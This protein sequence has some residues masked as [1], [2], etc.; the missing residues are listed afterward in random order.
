MPTIAAWLYRLLD[1][2]IDD[3]W[4]NH[5]T[6]LEN[7]LLIQGEWETGELFV[8]GVALRPT[9]WDDREK[10]WGQLRDP[11]R[12]FWWGDNSIE[13]RETARAI[14]EWFLDDQELSMYLD[15]FTTDVV[16]KFPKT[17]FELTFNYVGWRSGNYA[18]W[19]WK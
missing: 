6:V 13:S 2:I 15:D 17:D 14:L 16:A 12:K 8:H 1:W 7:G 4:A 11:T 18:V 9:G 5:N 19:S 10:P 3:Q